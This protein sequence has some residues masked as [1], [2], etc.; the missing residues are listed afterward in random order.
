MS[1]KVTSEI[2]EKIKEK[3]RELAAKKKEKQIIVEGESPILRKTKSV[4][5]KKIIVKKKTGYKFTHTVSQ[6]EIQTYVIDMIIGLILNL[7][8]SGIKYPIII[9]DNESAEEAKIRVEQEA[10]ISQLKRDLVPF[11]TRVEELMSGDRYYEHLA[12][13]AIFL[14][15]TNPIGK[16]AELFQNKVF[17][18]VYT[19]E[20]LIA[21][22][23]S[24][25]V[26]EVLLNPNMDDASQ[27]NTLLKIE[28]AI[29]AKAAFLKEIIPHEIEKKDPTK[30][31]NPHKV[32][33]EEKFIPLDTINAIPAKEMCDNASWGIKAVNIII[34]KDQ[35]KFYCLNVENLLQELA[36]TGTVSNYF[37]GKPL[38]AEIKE[39]LIKRYSGE[40]EKIKAGSSVEIGKWTEQDISHIKKSQSILKEIQNNMK[41]NKDISEPVKKLPFLERKNVSSEWVEEKLG[42]IAKIVP[43]KPETPLP[44]VELTARSKKVPESKV[45]RL[46]VQVVA[47]QV[48]KKD[49]F[50]YKLFEMYR[51]RLNVMRDTIF[52]TLEKTVDQ[53]S[54]NVLSKKIADTYSLIEKLNREMKTFDGV[55]SRIEEEIRLK[56]AKVAGIASAI[57]MN[58]IIP[59]DLLVAQQEKENLQ[60]Y[61]ADLNVE[62]D[63]IKTLKSA[64][65]EKK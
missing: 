17:Q 59:N 5:G 24:E 30:K 52:K 6:E 55:I 43:S 20:R 54:R 65:L 62:L 23:L 14:D 36:K 61:I 47:E 48:L 42:E 22:E 32:H 9:D 11:A 57:G 2:L 44:G 49:S 21:L 26:P 33:A 64:T 40:V 19:P 31:Q 41:D 4:K 35:G 39:N 63:Y 3:Q 38:H 56:E 50:A 37:T 10:E 25:I 51:S 60:K 12:K 34:C 8:L 7:N 13:L 16:F 27:G 28:E 53:T 29:A 18:R 1:L 58:M 46:E 45:E 15:K